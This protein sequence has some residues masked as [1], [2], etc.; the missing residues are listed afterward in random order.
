MNPPL[1]T[2]RCVSRYRWDGDAQSPGVQVRFD[3][4]CSGALRVR[5]RGDAWCYTAR[6]EHGVEGKAPLF[7]RSRLGVARLG[8][9]GLE[10]LP[11]QLRLSRTMRYKNTNKSTC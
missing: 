7:S 1:P 3:P 2:H 11:D 8:V 9:P 10:V 5:L 6:S 4:L